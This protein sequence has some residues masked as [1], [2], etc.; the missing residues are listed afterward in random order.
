VS[1]VIRGIG[2]LGAH[3]VRRLVQA[4]EVVVLFDGH[5]DLKAVRNLVEHVARGA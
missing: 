1:I 5:S 2:L 4:G 3:L